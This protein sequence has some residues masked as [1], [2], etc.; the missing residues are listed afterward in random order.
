MAGK[1][2][3]DSARVAY[4]HSSCNLVPLTVQDAR[5]MTDRKKAICPKCVLMDVASTTEL[6]QSP[7][8]LGAT[9]CG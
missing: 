7:P 1:Q 8:R 4:L 3:G 9:E 5:I 6:T 2:S